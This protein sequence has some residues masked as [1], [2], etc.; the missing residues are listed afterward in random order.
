MVLS[1][2]LKRDRFPAKLIP[3]ASF[4]RRRKIDLHDDFLFRNAPALVFITADT[5]LDAGLAAQNMELMAVSNGLGALY[6]GYLAG[7]ANRI[8]AVREWLSLSPD[9]TIHAWVCCLD[10][11]MYFMKELLRAGLQM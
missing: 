8:P 1:S 3:F 4:Y 9:E 11:P 2:L 6:N 7:I 5:A 10:I